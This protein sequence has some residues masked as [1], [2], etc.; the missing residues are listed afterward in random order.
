M[1][2]GA[3]PLASEEP[4]AKIIIDPPVAHWL[5]QGMVVIQYRTENPRIVQVA[6]NACNPRRKRSLTVTPAFSLCWWPR[7]RVLQLSNSPLQPRRAPDLAGIMY[8]FA[9]HAIFSALRSARRARS[10]RSAIC[11]AARL[12]RAR[13][14]CRRRTNSADST[15]ITGHLRNV[16]CTVWNKITLRNGN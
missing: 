6:R 12:R 2:A 11:W 5:A 1:P 10:K 9:A 16:G 8:S 15:K 4:P 3:V 13:Q 14:A 7:S